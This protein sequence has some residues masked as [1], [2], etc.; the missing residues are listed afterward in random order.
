[1]PRLNRL[2]AGL[3]L[4]G[5][6]AGCERPVQEKTVEV[7]KV[8][9]MLQVQATLQNYARGQP[10]ASEVTSYDYMVEEVR[11]VHPE[12]ADIL[13]A[14]LEDLKKTKGSPAPKARALLTKLGLEQPTALK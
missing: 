6:V 14:G 1:M 2:L 8:D 7:Q 13:K 4:A 12:K 10:L 9:P 5:L 11:K 3:A